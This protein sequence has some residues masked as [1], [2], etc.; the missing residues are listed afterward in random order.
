MQRVLRSMWFHAVGKGMMSHRFAA[1][2][3]HLLC[4]LSSLCESTYINLR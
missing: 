4:L 3:R 2:V 1:I